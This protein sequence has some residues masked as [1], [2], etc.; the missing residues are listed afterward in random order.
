MKGPGLVWTAPAAARDVGADYAT[1]D[2]ARMTIDGTTWEAIWTSLS[3]LVGDAYAEACPEAE[4]VRFDHG[5]AT[6]LFDLAGRTQ[7]ERTVLVVSRPERPSMP[8][9]TAYQAGYPIPELVGGRPVDR[10]H[11]LAHSGGGLFGPNMFVQDRALNRGWSRQG[12]LYRA[13]ETRAV[14]T[15]GA[16]LFVRPHYVDDS[17]V[18]AVLDLGVIDDGGAEVYRFRNRYDIPVDEDEL[19]VALNGANTTQIGSF[20][21]ETAAAYLVRACG[22]TIVDLGDAGTPRDGQAHRIDLVAV[23]D[24]APIAFE[25]KT[26]FVG[27]SAGKR[28]R[29][30][31]LARPRMQRPATLSGHKQGSQGHVA[32]HLAQITDVDDNNAGIEVR[33]L[34]V[35]LLL[36]EIQQFGFTDSGNRLTPLEGPADCTDA[37]RTA[38]ARIGEH[39]GQP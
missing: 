20:G 11:Y 8:R 2:L 7:A 12:R 34:L 9:E 15:P 27:R 26:R 38:L 23:L 6:Y 19:A 1:A 33:V 10:G 35:D 13:L 24:D 37:A 3:R 25:V 30:G 32:A 5:A 31:N 39:R 4:I 29:L 17:D 18:P 36:M 21:E 28:T 16:I 22:A 14:T